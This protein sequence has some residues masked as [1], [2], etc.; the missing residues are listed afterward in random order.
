MVHIY[1]MQITL[2]MATRFMAVSKGTSPG[3]SEL[4]N[5]LFIAAY[6]HVGLASSMYQKPELS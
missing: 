1:V 4:S 6:S 3:V 2:N 5:I